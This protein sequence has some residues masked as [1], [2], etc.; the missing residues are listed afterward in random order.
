MYSKDLKINIQYGIHT[1]IA[2]MIVNK[3]SELKHI[4][5]KILYIKKSGKTEAMGM[6]MLAIISM[7]IEKGD[8]IEI[9]SEDD[10]DISKKVVDEMC[11]FID[12]LDI[13]YNSM[14]K[15]D[16]ILEET[17]IAN[18]QI[19]ENIPLGIIVIDN[20]EY[21]TTINK[22]ALTFL[23]KDSKEILGKKINNVIPNSDL[24]KVL[25]TKEREIG[26][27]FHFNGHML[28]S[29]ISPII[30]K[31][32]VLGAISVFQNLSEITGMKELN[33]RL[34]KILAYSHDAICFIDENR[35][36]S[37][38]NPAYE[39]I[40]NVS[41]DTMIGM[42]LQDTSP[43][44]YRMHVFKTK[45]AIENVFYKKNGVN[46]IA[47][48]TPIFIDDQFKGVL[49][50]SKPITA[51]KDILNMLKESEEKVNYYKEELE[52][53]SKLSKS[54]SGMIGNS[55]TL[56]DTLLM[57]DK[58]SQSSSTVLIRGE[59]G[60][61]KEL[62]AHAIHHSSSRK[63]KPF[64]RVNCAAIPENLLESELFGYEKGAFTGAVKSKPGKFNIAH[65][66]TIF[67]D[68]IGDMPKSMQ[69]KLLRVLQEREFES[70]GGLITQKVDVRVIAA[71]NRNLEEMI[72]SGDFR[73]DLYYRLNVITLSLPPLKE[74]K[75]DIYLLIDHFLNIISKKL[76]KSCSIESEALK[77]L[78]AYH[79]P[80][81]IRELENVI[82]RAVALCD[83]F[84][85]TPKDLPIYISNYSLNNDNLINLRNG[86]V[87]TLEE[88]EKEI[89]AAAMK[90]YKSYNRAGKAL[91]LTHRTVALKCKKYNIEIP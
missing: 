19:L 36:I 67:L 66:G 50:I 48:I 56:K 32:R 41:S 54:F 40:L 73:E 45:T 14:S 35:K 76:D 90:K 59:S 30:Y 5:N 46:I 37:Y 3:A 79:W 15:V 9:C 63:N 53:Q 23:K 70:V 16:A 57:A 17:T 33:E 77:L 27:S 6:S 65:G 7:K 2:A 4:H 60:T 18:E 31:D 13:Y 89:I 34:K 28:L 91:G 39:K 20:N 86:E 72:H 64:V 61:G 29:N 43:D 83:N 25:R 55:T 80:G 47:S 8:H 52:R 21:I 68:E 81:N 82:E 69:V 38:V 44:G 87:A 51:I 75:E 88:Y 10:D 42:D 1:R 62:L 11:R 58:A 74:R 85:I 26:K 12:N 71:T 84:L 49:S 78:S 24:P 22:Y